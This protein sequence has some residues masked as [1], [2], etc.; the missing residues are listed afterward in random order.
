MDI[1]FP[2]QDGKITV[3]PRGNS[4]YTSSRFAVDYTPEGDSYGDHVI[5]T[6]S[7]DEVETLIKVL[8]FAL[9]NNQ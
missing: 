9:E 4:L 6:L 7:I 1:S 5:P 3:S 8:T 2:V